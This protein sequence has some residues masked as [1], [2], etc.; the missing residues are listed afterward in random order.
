MAPDVNI[1]GSWVT[2][3]FGKDVDGMEPIERA[4]M[5]YLS[6]PGWAKEK[7]NAQVFVAGK[8]QS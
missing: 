3:A 6:N 5:T 2:G 1:L 7:H 4:E 8:L